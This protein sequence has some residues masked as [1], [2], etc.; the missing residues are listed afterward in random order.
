MDVVSAIAFLG[1]CGGLFWLLSRH[2][3]HWVSKDGYRMIARV[4]SLGP[5]D[6][7]EGTWKDVRVLVDGEHLI[8]SSRGPRAWKLRGRYKA[9]AKSPDPPARREIYILQGDVRI[10]LRIP[11]TSRAIVVIDSLL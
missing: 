4:Q 2:E 3:T 11:S 6:Q 8:V 10:L 5:G 9:L 7:P 1:V